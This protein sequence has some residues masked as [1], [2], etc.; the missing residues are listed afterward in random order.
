MVDYVPRCLKRTG[1]ASAALREE[2]VGVI[3]DIGSFRHFFNLSMGKE[4]GTSDRSHLV[5]SFR[6]NVVCTSQDDVV[7]KHPATLTINMLRDIV[8]LSEGSNTASQPLLEFSM[9]QG[10]LPTR[11]ELS[12]IH[13]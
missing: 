4:L 7:T 8:T 6:V 10:V 11:I 1:K 12:L 5:P 9:S 13:I 3:D 2:Q